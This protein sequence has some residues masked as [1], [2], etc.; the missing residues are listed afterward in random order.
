[1]AQVVALEKPQKGNF[2]VSKRGPSAATNAGL[3]PAPR[4]DLRP[5]TR[6]RESARALLYDKPAADSKE[7]SRRSARMGRQL[8]MLR[9]HGIIKK[10]SRTHRY[11]VTTGGR[12]ILTATLTAAAATRI[13]LLWG[14]AKWDNSCLK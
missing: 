9:A 7:Q 14:R 8:R 4:E 12:E 13:G 10:V 5:S 11:Q 2:R 3:L 6:I 1:M